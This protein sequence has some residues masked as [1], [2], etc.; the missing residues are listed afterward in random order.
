MNHFR[1]SAFRLNL[2]I[3]KYSEVITKSLDNLNILVD[4][5]TEDW[6]RLV[7]S[8]KPDAVELSGNL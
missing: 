1:F 8:A 7:S 4:N 6:K 2:L 5:K 3:L